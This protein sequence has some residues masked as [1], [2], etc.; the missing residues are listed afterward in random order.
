MREIASAAGVSKALLYHYFPSKIDLFKEA[1]SEAAGELAALIR[2]ASG[3]T[4]APAPEQLAATLDA[5]LA[6]IDDHARTWTKLMQSAATLPEA[7][8]IVERF[9]AETMA[10]VLAG[11]GAAP[12]LRRR[13]GPRSSAGSASWTPRSSTGRRTATSPA[14]SSGTCSSRRSARPCSPDRSSALT[15]LQDLPGTIGWRDAAAARVR[16]DRRSRHGDYAVRPSR[17][18]RAALSGRAS[19]AAGVR[20]GIVVGLAITFTIAIVALAQLV[21]GVGLASGA[22]RTLAI[23]VLIGFGLILLIPS[24][25]ARVQA[26]LS[27]LARFGPK[28]RGDGFWSGVGVG[29]ALGF[30]CAP[31]AG[32]ILAAVTSVSASSGPSARIVAVAIAYAL[33]LSAVLLLYAIGGRA[34][35]ERIR[36]HARGHLVEPVLG[37]VLI[38]TGVAMATNL[39]VRFEEALAKDQNLPAFLVNP[40]R[41]LENSHA[42]QSRLASLRPPSKFASTAGPGEQ[43]PPSRPGAGV[44]RHP[45]MVQHARRAPAHAPRAP[46]SRRARRLLDVYVHQ[47]HPHAPVPQGAVRHL[48][49]LRAADRRRGDAGVHV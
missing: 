30:V 28:T 27:R 11:L 17:A 21:Q 49:P 7:R 18:P 35:L 40:T 15:R 4:A 20:F 31:C 38:L 9:R 6:W 24:L 34:V 23:V 5:Y 46:R 16:A 10:M 8:E 41:A 3:G 39:D 29:G 12:T 43:P 25:A 22:A 1:V 42:V 48:S 36:R 44:H 26:P 2:P 13:S 47:L 37:V 14:T 45:A 32:P 33:G 19:A